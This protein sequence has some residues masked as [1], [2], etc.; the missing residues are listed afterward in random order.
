MSSRDSDLLAAVRTACQPTYAPK[1]EEGRKAVL[2]LPRAWVVANIERVVETGL[3]LTDYWKY[4][5]LLELYS[6]LDPALVHRLV[7][8]GE[9]SSD[10]EI[11][12][13]ARDFGGAA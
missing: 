6:L 4:R 12:E 8:V 5:R 3:D 7:K 2:G 11:A 1:I 13:A 9:A 10:P